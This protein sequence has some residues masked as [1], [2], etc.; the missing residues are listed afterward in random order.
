ME[1]VESTA[2]GEGADRDVHAE[3]H[4][5][6]DG[7]DVGD[8][9]GRSVVVDE[10]RRAIADAR[11][12]PVGV[13]LSGNPGMGKTALLAAAGEIA[14]GFQLLRAG[15]I[16][17]ESERPFAALH[18]LL[19]PVK[20]DLARLTSRQRDAVEAAIS[21]EASVP[22]DFAVGAGLVFVLS[23]AAERGPLLIAID[24]AQWLDRG[25]FRALLF[26]FRRLESE[27]VLML[28]AARPQPEITDLR[29]IGLRQVRLGPLGADSAL[30]LAR[31]HAQP[32]ADDTALQRII[33]LGAGVP[34]ALVE[35]AGAHGAAELSAA[36]TAGSVAQLV[37][38]LF[39]R[40]L[41]Q[42]SPPAGTAALIATLDDE[43]QL[44]AFVG[45]ATR[46][47]IDVAAWEEAERAGVLRIDAGRATFAHP[48]LREAVLA[49]AMPGDRRRAHL[50]LAEAMT[51]QGDPDRALLHKAA[52]TFGT[53][54]ALATR[55]E[56]SAET[57]R[58]RAGHLP[59]AQ[60]LEHAAR[61]SPA[62]GDRA[63]RLLDAG[64]S[65]RRAGSGDWAETLAVQARAASPDRLLHARSEF[66]QAHV[67]SRRGSMHAA[68]RRYMR[69]ADQ[70]S[71]QDPDLTAMTLSYAASAAIVVGDGAGAVSA[72]RAASEL[73]NVSH[74]TLVSVREAFGSVLALLGETR[75]ARPLLEEVAGWYEAQPERVG[76]EYVAEAL[77]WL[78]DFPRARALLDDVASDARRLGAPAL[79]VQTLVLRADLGYRTGDWPAA[80]ADASE[81]VRLAEDTEQSIPLAYALAVRAILH[82]ATGS[83]DEAR[84]SAHLAREVAS[85]HGLAVVAESAG[86][87][88]GALELAAGTPERAVLELEP[89][90]TAVAS[91]GRGEPAVALWPADLIEALIAVDR[92]TA[93]SAALSR[94]GAQADRTSGAWARGVVHRYRGVMAGGEEY[95]TMFAQAITCHT[96]SAM[97]FELARTRLCYGQRLRR[98]GRRV[99]AREQ[100]RQALATFH[101]LH[102][103]M[104]VTRAER[105]LAGS[106]EILRPASAA[107]RD[108]LT[109]QELQIARFIATGATNREAAAE[110]FLSPKTI[111]THL[112]RIYRKLG[113]RSRSQLTLLIGRE[114]TNEP[115]VR[116]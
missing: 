108:E 63:R 42:L 52:G 58:A 87:A 1:R 94:L 73:T 16:Q 28:L 101:T 2:S 18:G 100:L 37:E 91:T 8:L 115:R 90:A 98:D 65:A 35:L 32:E 54:E 106:G 60:A 55:L 27:R 21:L 69:V 56:G 116:N 13:L 104:W 83:A 9:I 99:S 31:R 81:A 84:A 89:V 96:E 88:L 68:F 57:H 102:A 80:L 46:L 5:A 12:G 3:S 112:T 49:R 97:P 72:A 20:G 41:D 25:T 14:E 77:M 45:A 17:L 86:F 23:A 38:R 61:L 66:L 50:A 62:V 71:G 48:L 110:L 33:H 85:R 24:D 30:Q 59:A 36:E 70:A 114:S 19:G 93:A 82:A 44:E 15:G 22:D 6:G 111:E 75:Q 40:R 78:G 92:R 103:T 79:L 109:P 47:H 67:E 51:A 4:A 113:V 10:L 76:A 43:T 64:D 7:R 74:E 95:D 11:T 34:L 107:G 39:G 105:E 26:A 53:N 29:L